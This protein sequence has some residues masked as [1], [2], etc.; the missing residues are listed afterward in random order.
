MGTCPGRTRMGGRRGAG[1]AEVA[2]AEGTPHQ[3]GPPEEKRDLSLLVRETRPLVREISICPLMLGSEGRGPS[4]L[5][6]IGSLVLYSPLDFTIQCLAV[7]SI[8]FR[9]RQSYDVAKY[10]ALTTLLRAPE[11]DNCVR[12]NK[13]GETSMIPVT[14]TRQ[15]GALLEA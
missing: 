5:G 10:I 6:E 3:M 13:G 14:L 7:V 15:G 12:R 9:R 11:F 4:L 8:R 2:P 1:A